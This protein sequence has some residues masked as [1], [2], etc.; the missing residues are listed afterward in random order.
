M[1]EL[2]LANVMPL[3]PACLV[4][5]AEVWGLCEGL[6]AARFLGIIYLLV[7]GDNLVVI[8]SIRH[9]WKVLWK[10]SSLVMDSADL[11]KSFQTISVNH[12]FR[13]ANQAM[14]FVL[15]CIG[16]L[17]LIFSFSSI[18]CKDTVG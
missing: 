8:N 4:L 1:G 11:M 7:E 5:K 10:I 9:C 16:F 14:K 17:L 15:L 6:R 3:S 18:I 13:E 2:C 12:C